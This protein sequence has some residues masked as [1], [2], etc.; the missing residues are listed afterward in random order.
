MPLSLSS[1]PSVQSSLRFAPPNTTIRLILTLWQ[2]I[3]AMEADARYIRWLW[4]ILF[5][6]LL[7]RLVYAMQ[8]PTVATFDRATGDSG[9]FHA[10]GWGFFSGQEHGW[11]RGIPFTNAVIPTPPLYI[12]FT[13]ILQQFLPEHE[14]VVAI[15]LLQCLASIATAYLAFRIGAVL[16]GARAGVVSAAFAAFHPA[17]ILET[18]Q[19]R[20][21]DAIHLFSRQRPLAIRGI[22]CQQPQRAESKG[23]VPKGGSCLGGDRFQFG[24]FDHAP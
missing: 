22:L 15:R 20:H 5:I 12:I 19:H 10:V 14:T 1:V 18:G 17:L 8:Q 23:I 16:G 6:G 21:R 3:Q 7:L 9:W 4:V 24:N 2:D 11:I 13:G